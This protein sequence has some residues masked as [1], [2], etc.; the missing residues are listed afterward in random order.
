MARALLRLGRYADAIA[1]LEPALRGSTE[2]ANLYA[3]HPEVRLQ[4][5]QA[6]AGAGKFDRANAELEWVR[7]AWVKADPVVRPQLDS[8]ARVVASRRPR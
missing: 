4:L 7:R 6:Y 8:A 2:A 3:T 1:V 5:A